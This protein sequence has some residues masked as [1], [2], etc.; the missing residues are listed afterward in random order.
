MDI[1]KDDSWYGQL[2][3]SG[4]GTPINESGTIFTMLGRFAA[5]LKASPTPRGKKEFS[6]LFAQEPFGAE[7]ASREEAAKIAEVASGLIDAGIDESKPKDGEAPL[8][9][10]QRLLESGYD[11][12]TA[13]LLMNDWFDLS[14]SPSVQDVLRWIN[15]PKAQRFRLLNASQTEYDSAMP[16]EYDSLRHYVLREYPDRC[17][18]IKFRTA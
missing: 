4:V 13:M 11:D 5:H 17:A 14:D 7:K 15:D 12:A 2:Q 9:Y 6:I 3:I 16:Q 8:D 10:F 1:Q 18:D